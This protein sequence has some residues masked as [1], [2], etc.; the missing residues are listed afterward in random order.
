MKKM[1]EI[2][3]KIL[4][5]TKKLGCP[6]EIYQSWYAIILTCGGPRL[7]FRG[8]KISKLVFSLSCV[9]GHVKI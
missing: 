9:D 5:T 7:F 1:V 6:I 3:K 4:N 2:T 8:G